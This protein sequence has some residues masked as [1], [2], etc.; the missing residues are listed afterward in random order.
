MASSDNDQETELGRAF[1]EELLWVHSMV[2]R[3]LDTVTRLANGAAAG[4]PPEDLKAEIHDLKTNG[5]LWRL[6]L[7]CLRYCR[8]VHSHHNL[9]DVALFPVLRGNNPALG[10]VVDK[11]EHDH[12]RVSHLLDGVEI[13]ANSLTI[14][15]EQ[16]TRQHL[17]EALTK[18][19][20]ELLAHL[21]FEE[22]N[23]GPTIRRLHAFP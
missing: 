21:E 6:K 1:F 15:D 23:A 22:R 11:L 12:K 8:F 10:L 3:D 7:G 13:A 19:A 5:H 2:R 16:P 17:S 20:E 4:E 14:K 9:E 18:L